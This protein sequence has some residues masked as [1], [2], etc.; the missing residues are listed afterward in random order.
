MRLLSYIVC[1]MF[2]GMFLVSCKPGV[3]REFIQPGDM[4][5]ILYDYHI[6][7]AMAQ[8]N[9]DNSGSREYNQTLYLEAVLAKHGVTRADFDSSLV[10][11]YSH[12]EDFSDI[13]KQ[14]AERLE[15]EARK[16]GATDGELNKYA[17]FTANGDTANIW[18]GNLSAVLVP[19]A[20]YNKLDFKVEADTAFRK[21][22]TFLFNFV[23]D[24]VYQSGAKDAVAY[25]M[26]KFEN[27]SVV[28]QVCHVSVSGVTRL[29]IV[30]PNDQAAKYIKG[31][32]Y[33]SDN[34]DAS[35]MVR[36]MFLDNIQLIRCRLKETV[37]ASGT[38]L[39]GDSLRADSLVND[40]MV[41]RDDI[42]KKETPGGSPRVGLRPA[43][44]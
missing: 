2:A 41:A 17:S 26:A 27:D 34:N 6:G 42:V 23:T 32:I 44:R 43:A 11:Y 38:M 28:T 22:D 9:D 8:L 21:G 10:Y 25:I 37:P 36:M 40:S 1:L 39:K 7:K 15:D 13:Y 18:T 31:F 14:V 33:L 20:P 12:S 30:S 19:K 4:E 3:P 35:T 29:R 16:L 24:Y 5:D